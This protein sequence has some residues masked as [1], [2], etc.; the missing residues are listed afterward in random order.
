MSANDST[1]KPSPR[2]T[3]AGFP[4]ASLAL[5][6]TTCACLLASAD[7]KRWHEQARE[8]S[9]NGSW[10][11]VI[12]IG[13]AGL[14]GGIIGLISLFFSRSKS[15]LRLLLPGAGMLAGEIGLFILMAPGPIWRTIFVVGIL[16]GAAIL[17][18]LDA[19]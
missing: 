4:I 9:A 8:L 10:L 7:I 5:L 3:A 2:R 14:I 16:L 6:I 13:T 11:F 17:L 18:R 1:A 12:L 15:R 19:D